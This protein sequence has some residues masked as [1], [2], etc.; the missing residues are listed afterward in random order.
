VAAAAVLAGGTLLLTAPAATADVYYA[1]CTAAWNAGAAPIHV[2]EPGYRRKLDSDHDGIACE[3]DPRPGHGGGGA[4]VPQS[5]SEQPAP[6]GTSSPSMPGDDT[7][8]VPGPQQGDA[9]SLPNTGT[10]LPIPLLIGAA[11]TLIIGG[12]IA[13]RAGAARIGRHRA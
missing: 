5:P 11:G 4:P 3:K 9:A 12:G 6:G 7:T 2:G 8:P 1:N 10:T 13:V